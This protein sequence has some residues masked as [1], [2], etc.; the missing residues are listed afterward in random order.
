LVVIEV[1]QEVDGIIFVVFELKKEVE[2]TICV[3]IEIKKKVEDPTTFGIKQKIKY[4]LQDLGLMLMSQPYPW[5]C[6]QGKGLQRCEPR[7][8]SGITFHALGSVGK[9]EGMNLHT[10]K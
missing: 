8:K 3:E 7:V 6:D 10:P 2:K 1:K 5:V 4:E 9:G